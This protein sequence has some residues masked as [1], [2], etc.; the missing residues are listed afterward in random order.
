MIHYPLYESGRLDPQSEALLT[1]LAS[2]SPPPMSSLS[3]AEAR[4]TFMPPS[5]LGKAKELSA[6]RD[7]SIPGPAGRIPVRTYV[8]RGSAPF[9]V[10]LFFHGGGFVL[11][12]LGD[13][14]AFCSFLAAGAG[15]IVVS[16]DYRLAPE[17]KYPAAVED[18]KAAIRW[19]GTQAAEI[20]GDPDRL[21][22]AGDSA[23]GNLAAVTALLARDER[24][25]ALSLQVLICPWVDLSSCETESFR[26]FGQG[27]W[28]STASIAWYRDHY[29]AEPDQAL[30]PRVS[31][32]LAEDL[33]GLP[34]ALVINAEFDVLRDQAQAYARRLEAQGN[35]V[36]Y[37]LYPGMLHDFPLLPGLFDRAR[38]AVDDVCLALRKAFA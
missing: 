11:G 14:D 26:L 7:L 27:I 37:R 16:V 9:P 29:L 30:S 4:A 38:E 3:P 2:S 24:F 35:A 20:G 33:T 1:E 10:L 18:A 13:F 28:L 31:P 23:G 36:E 25:P 34:P 17:E 8:P 6:S 22:L 32:L 12:A 19:L 15:C 5:W 21:A